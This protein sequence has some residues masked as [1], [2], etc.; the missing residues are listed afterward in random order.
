[1]S[2]GGVE[3]MKSNIVDVSL[4]LLGGLLF[5]VYISIYIFDESIFNMLQCTHV[6]MISLFALLY[7]NFIKKECF[8]INEM[9]YRA[10]NVVFT[11]TMFLF[12]LMFLWYIIRIFMNRS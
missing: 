7:I 12:F 8:S 3:Q 11:Y 5:P 1:M 4:I 2:S 9:R 10:Y 6:M